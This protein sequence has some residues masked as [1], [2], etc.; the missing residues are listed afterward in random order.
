MSEETA[1]S[2]R[3]VED[4]AG[5]RRDELLRVPDAEKRRDDTGRYRKSVRENSG[6]KN[7]DN[8]VGQDGC[9]RPCGRAR[10]QHKGGVP[11]GRRAAVDGDKLHTAERHRGQK[12][13]DGR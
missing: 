2:A 7:S 4:G 11:D 12:R 13:K 9:G 1:H 5:V 6:Q 10:V 3:N 8:R